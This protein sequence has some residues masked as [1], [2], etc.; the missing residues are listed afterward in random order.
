MPASVTVA[1]ILQI[2]KDPASTP[3]DLNQVITLDPVL[4]GKVLSLVNPPTT[5]YPNQSP[6][7]VVAIVMS[8]ST[9]SRTWRLRPRPRH[10]AQLAEEEGSNGASGGIVWPSGSLP[11]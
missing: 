7:I 6:Q 11:S 10:H 2:T 9:P 5:T 8:G 3:N 1:K 4:T